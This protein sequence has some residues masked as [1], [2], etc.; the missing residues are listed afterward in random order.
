MGKILILPDVPTGIE[1]GLPEG[2]HLSLPL[3]YMSDFSIMA[4]RVK[5]LDAARTLLEGAGFKLNDTPVALKVNFDSFTRIQDIL[6]LFEIHGIEAAFTDIAV[7]I[8]Q[9]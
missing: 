4:L 5:Q 8:Y 1:A 2:S 7:Q 3:N 9:G 6:A